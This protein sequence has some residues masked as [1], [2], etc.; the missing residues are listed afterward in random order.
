MH[1][2]EI[3]AELYVWAMFLFMAAALVVSFSY[4]LRQ[5]D[6]IAQQQQRIENFQYMVNSFPADYRNADGKRIKI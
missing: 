4:N 1:R 5:R 6:T 3:A 2:E